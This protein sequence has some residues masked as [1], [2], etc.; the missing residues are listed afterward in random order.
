MIL[1]VGATGQL[2]DLITRK[3]LDRG[4]AVRILVREGSECSTLVAAGAETVAGDLKDR[5]SLDAACIG[6]HAIITTAN[7]TARG[8]TDTVESVDRIGNRNLIEAAVGARVSRFIFI[9]NLG[10]DPHN[11]VP[12]MAAK[13]ETEEL[14]RKSGMCW[15]IVQPDLFMDKLPVIVVGAPALAGQPVTLVGEGRR[16]HS[17]VAMRDVAQYTIAALNYPEAE[18]ETLVVGGPE[19]VS[20]RDVVAAF[21]HELGRDVPVQTVPLGQPTP[22]MPDL[23]NGF[24]NGLET[25]DSRLDTTSLSEQYKVVP[26]TLQEW[27]HDFV[28][29]HNQT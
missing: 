23:I 10:A 25:Y 6:V 18:H 15:T 8:G 22:G 13:G 2:G 20:W 11:P 12:F 19:P 7:S 29:S 28:K 24:L 26:S 4:N 14:L 17:L 16:V 5:P 1:V 27:V 3:L 21:E 9:S